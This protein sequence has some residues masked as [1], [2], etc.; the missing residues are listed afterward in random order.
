MTWSARVPWGF[1]IAAILAQ[2][3]WPLTSGSGRV[4]NTTL[5]VVL[6]AAA[7]VSH[8]AVTRGVRWAA[9]YTAMALGVGLGVEVLGVSTG[10]PFS[11]YEYT[12]LLQPQLFGVPLLIPVA[13]TMMAY[14]AWLVGRR[15]AG[16]RPFSAV[17]IG[18]FALASWDVFLDPQMVGENY[19]VWLSDEPGLPGIPEIPLA[20]YS[21]WLLV[22]LVLIGAVSLLPTDRTVRPWTVPTEGV[23]TLLYGWTWLGGIVANAVFLG[24]PVVALWGGLI[25]GVVAVPYLVGAVRDS[26]GTQAGHHARADGE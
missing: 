24:R 8:A 26:R 9:G 17:V 23:P 15:L 5:V 25:M 6:F 2:I 16:P 21:G 14:P 22:S 3:A 1:A 20:N 18:A 19:W 13:W 12:E 10:F 7:S 11:A 4:V